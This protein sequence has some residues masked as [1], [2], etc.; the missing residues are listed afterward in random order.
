MSGTRQKTL[1]EQLPQTLAAEGRGEALDAEAEDAEPLMAKPAP[2]SPGLAEHLMEEVC[3]RGTTISSSLGL[4]QIYAPAQASLGRTAV[5]RT[6]MPGGVGGVASR[7]APLSRS[8][9]D[10]A[11]S[12]SRHGM[13]A[14][15]AFLPLDRDRRRAGVRPFG[16]RPCTG[17]EGWILPSRRA[18]SPCGR[19]RP[20]MVNLAQAPPGAREGRFLS[21]LRDK[22]SLFTQIKFPVPADKA[23]C[24]REQ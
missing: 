19:G 13:L 12:P 10:L 7:G 3:D 17:A 21:L 6:R 20:S 22:N 2:E 1:G 24:Y 11:R 15:C 18:G 23:P 8:R 9:V 16:R 14:P 5:V 4:P